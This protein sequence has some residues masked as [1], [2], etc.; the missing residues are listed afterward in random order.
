MKRFSS[1]SPV[2]AIILISTTLLS[3]ANHNAG[4][5]QQATIQHVVLFWLNTPG[6]QSSIKRITNAS[7][8]LS[9]IPGVVKVVVGTSLPSERPVVDTSYDLAAI[10]T[11][12]TE[13]AYRSYLVNPVHLKAYNDTLLPLVRR[14]QIYDIAISPW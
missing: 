13:Q 1:V 7:Q 3:C 6:D 12:S 2:L 9:S 8:S 11:F 10:I 4:R 14:I 5:R